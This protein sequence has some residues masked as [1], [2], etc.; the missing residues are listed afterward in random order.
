[1]AAR[2]VALIGHS[3][4]GKSS[5]LDELQADRTTADMD[6]VLGTKHSPQLTR[7]LGWLATEEQ[8]PRLVAISNHESMLEE[9][10]ASKITGQYAKQF[11]CVL[12]V[13]LH[14]PLDELRET[15]SRPSAGGH[16]RQE[17][18]VQYTIENYDRFHTLFSQLADR[19]VSCSGKSIKAVAAEV[20]RILQTLVEKQRDPLSST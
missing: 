11:G 9:M 2:R 20:Q 5:V 1:M 12:L 13:Y 7:A 8:D 4:A 3:G 17:A 19:V 16:L 18:G 6:A 14:R 10:R 15:L